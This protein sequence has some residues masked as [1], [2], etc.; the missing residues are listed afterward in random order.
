MANFTVTC[1]DPRLPAVAQQ[2]LDQ[3]GGKSYYSTAIG[4]SLGIECEMAKLRQAVEL[5][6]VDRINIVDHLTCKAY[7]LTFGD[8][9]LA[10]ERRMHEDQLR[11]AADKVRRALPGVAVHIYLLVKTSPD[12][13]DPEVIE[14]ATT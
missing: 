7:A 2:V 11:D 1:V 4:G 6:H 8:K 14:I 9:D 3:V 12:R 5:L 10:E 13:I